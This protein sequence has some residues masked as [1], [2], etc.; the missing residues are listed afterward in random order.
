M[1]LLIPRSFDKIIDLWLAEDN[2][3]INYHAYLTGASPITA[4]LYCKDTG[5]VSG[6]AFFTRIFEKV[7]CTVE[8]LV[9]DG[10][11][12]KGS[13]LEK[14]TIA[15]VKGKACDILE[16]ERIGLNIITHSSAISTHCHKFNELKQKHGWKGKVAAT[17][18]TLP[19]L[20]LVE[21]MAVISGGG[22]THRYDLSSCLMIKDNHIKALGSIK[23]A[24]VKTREVLSFTSK[25]EVECKNLKEGIEAIENGADI[26]MLDNYEPANAAKDAQELKKIRPSIIIEISGGITLENIEAY[27]NENIDIISIGGLTQQT[28]KFDFSLKV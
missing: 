5:V 11:F 15:Y 18:K 28:E 23:N 26:I 9:K 7:D 12:I 3:S 24:I 8:W 14:V 25:V 19:G 21:K 27:F 17:R 13:N 20:R 22:D 1:D 10:D 4:T 16:G 2:P 6:L